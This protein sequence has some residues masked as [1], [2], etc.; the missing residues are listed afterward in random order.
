MRNARVLY[1]DA[2]VCA[3]RFS[4]INRKLLYLLALLVLVPSLV[5]AQ[6][7]TGTISGTVRD[8]TGAVVPDAMVTVRNTATGATRVVQTASD[9][10]YTVPSLTPSLYDVTASKTGFADYKAQATVTVGSRVTLDIPLSVSQVST[11]VEVVAVAGGGAEINTQT[12]EISQIITPEQVANLPSLTRN[13][14]DFVALAGNVSAGDRSVSSANPQIAGSGQNSTDRGV[15]FSI[16]GQRASGTEVL[17]DGAENTNIFDTTIAL[18]IPQDAV[19]EYRVITNNF[20]AQYGR[21]SG[22][23]VDV[24]TK[25]GTGNFHGDAWEFNRLS[26]YT[27]NTF[28]NNAQGRDAAGNLNAPKGQYTRNQ[29]GYDVGGPIKKDKLFFYQSTEWLRVRSAATNLAY[30]PT[31]QLLA[32]LPA[33]VQAFFN[34]YG[35]NNFTF[36]STVPAGSLS[37]LGSKKPAPIFHG[38][39]PDATPAFGLVSYAAPVDAGG[40]VPQ[41]TYTLVGRFDYNFSSNTQAFF[42]YGRESLLALPGSVVSDAYQQYNVG[43]TIYNNNFL[44]SVNHS[45]RSNFLSTTK[46]SYFRDDSSEQYNTA[47]QETPTLFLF[48][49]ATI[50]GQSVNLPGFSPF[51]TGTGGLPFG[52]PQNTIQIGEDVSWSKGKHNMRFGGQYNYIQLDRGFGAYA[53]A[54]EQIG[55]DL[56]SGLNNLA[57]GILTDFKRAVNPAGVLPCAVGPYTGASAGPVIVTPACTLSFPITEP[58]F[59]RSY[60]Y[61][62]WAIYAQDSWRV[63]PRFTFNYGVRYEHYGVQHNN[64]PNL[65]SNL[66]YGPGANIFQQINTAQTLTVPN[67]PIKGLWKPRWGTVGPRIGF[68]Y[69]VFGDGKTSLR[70][71]YGISYERNFGNVTF[72]MIQNPPNNATV[73]ISGGVV[74]ITVSNLGPFAGA[75]CPTLPAK[76]CVLPPVS[77]R[78]VAQDIQVAQTQFWGASIERQLG[79]K[80]VVSLEYNGAHGVHLY[81]IANVNE[82]GVGQV[83]LG[84]SAAGGLTRANQQYSSINNRGSRGFS[85]Y[86]ALNVKL[87]TH[88]VGRTGVTFQGNYTYAHSLDNLSSTFSENSTGSNGIG[89]LGYTNPADVWLDY[90]NSDF[91]IR[92][93]LAF[94]AIWQEPFFKSGKG[95]LRQAAGGWSISPI[96]TARTGTPFSIADSSN[97]LNCLTGP[98]GIPRYVP[99][100][101]VPSFHAGAGTDTGNP[102]LF[103]L[104]TL[105]AA[106]SFSGL[107]GVSDFGP[108]PAGM[109]TRNMFFG[110]GAWSFDVAVAKSF[111]LTERFSLEFRAEGFNIFNHANMYLNGFA[112]DVGSGFPSGATTS[113]GSVVLQGL[114]GGLG[115]LANNGQHDE[116]RFGQF[117]LRLHF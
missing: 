16:N 82:I 28:T 70:G 17:L 63:T 99:S 71:G 34:A 33:P 80:A 43:E 101:A 81:D 117:A 10:V 94:S 13:P 21:A 18:L 108:Y 20:D 92:H 78:N 105:P 102:N 72:N 8:T 98:Y 9:G 95:F 55:K 52:G 62:D 44:L 58:S 48:N 59:N 41:N 29:F 3:F 93:R 77:P 47:L 23:V 40:D 61:N 79:G 60:R 111:F 51:T 24:I 112:A 2:F 69:D 73:D 91:D 86:N 66:Y 49:N 27:S 67:S 110:P 35:N 6:A 57:S 84:Q 25:S 45:F 14:Y 42:R 54:N 31:P 39:V 53:Q 50:L 107:L 96:F 26:A 114:K 65:D 68:A 88:E 64:N 15:G 83:Y 113:S 109:T 76:P 106:N 75:T 36:L 56:A 115:N 22:G 97:C 37:P 30:V 46:L 5:F 4:K 1:T 12:A 74:P 104:L 32:L 90:G 85:H 38:L 89:N 100:G 19:Q 11:T 87:E 7:D 103:T 116:R